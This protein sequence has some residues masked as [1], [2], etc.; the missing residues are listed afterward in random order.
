[1]T[2]GDTV[3]TRIGRTLIRHTCGGE[4]WEGEV[5]VREGW[6]TTYERADVPLD[7]AVSAAAASPPDR[8]ASPAEA[9][10]ADWLV[11]G[12]D[13]GPLPSPDPEMEL[14]L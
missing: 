10:L 13:P 9:I 1:M 2:E 4:V 12:S 5:W 6:V 11:L 14:G 8:L 3:E 7:R